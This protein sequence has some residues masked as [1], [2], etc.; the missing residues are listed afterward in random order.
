[1]SRIAGLSW[2]PNCQKLAVATADRAVMLFDENGERKDK[3]S[4]KPGDP[5]GSRA[6]YVIRGIAFSPDSTRLAVA[7]SDNIV[8]VYKLGDSW[9]DKKVICNKFPQTFAV[10]CMIWL[11]SGIIIAGLEDGRVR[12]LHC[13]NN[14]SQNLYGTEAMVIALAA[15]SRFS[16][17]IVS[18]HDDG[19]VIR[20]NVV[21][22]NNELS[23]GRL[24]QHSVSPTALAWSS[25][26]IVAAGC[27][28]KV[29][30]YDSQGRLQRC[31]DYSRDD[32]EREF[33]VATCS[34]N[35]QAVAI[36]SFDRIRVYTWSPRQ[37]LWSESLSKDIPN[38][39]SIIALSWRKDGS[40]LTLG[41]SCGAV[42]NFE[43]VI[44]RT[45]WQDKF[46][47]TFVAPSQVLLKS[48]QEHSNS[49]IVESQMGLE[50]EDVKIMGKLLKSIR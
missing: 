45:I 30:F 8:Y 49:M 1:M 26:G 2:S 11:N 41:T 42:I 5:S 13:K 44:K 16:G 6:S 32:N 20:F 48:L 22:E 10:S 7:Q 50:I 47:I 21:E 34:P 40:R 19:S 23:N 43:S 38:L 29:N 17:T 33:M 35:G 4:T 39:Y 36:G 9:N 15:N 37:N 18:G 28:K 24:F 12:A 31:F 25:G 46:E 3:F 27:D 14:K